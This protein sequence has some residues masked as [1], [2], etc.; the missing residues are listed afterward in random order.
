MATRREP[1]SAATA[2]GTL[3]LG[4]LVWV[5]AS[6]GRAYHGKCTRRCRFREQTNPRRRPR[7]CL[8]RL[9]ILYP[10]PSCPHA[11]AAL[12]ALTLTQRGSRGETLISPL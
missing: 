2:R 7:F 3:Y 10:A 8:A 1:G 11:I 5:R 12:R 6:S 9:C 4:Y